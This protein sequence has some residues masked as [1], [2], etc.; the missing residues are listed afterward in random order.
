[1]KIGASRLSSAQ[2]LA[3][4]W[5]GLGEEEDREEEMEE[6]ADAGDTERRRESGRR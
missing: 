4:P 6:E 5:S 1:M 3:Q 2:G